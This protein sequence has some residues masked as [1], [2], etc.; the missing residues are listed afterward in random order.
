MSVTKRVGPV[1]GVAALALSGAAFAESGTTDQDLQAR[2]AD[3]EAQVAQLKSKDG[4]QWLTEQRAKEIR[5]IVQDVLQDADTR[6]S[7]LQGGMAAGHDSNGFFIGSDDGNFRL[8]VG[9]QVQ[10]RYMISIQDDDNNSTAPGVPPVVDTTRGGFEV[11]RAKL[12]FTGHV[13][14]PNWTYR[15]S[16]DFGQGGVFALDDGYINYDFDN[17][18]SFTVGQFKLPGLREEMVDSAYQQFV[19]RSLLASSFTLWRSQGVMLNYAGEWFRGSAAFSDGAL[20]ANSPSLGY[21]TEYAFSLR[22]EILFAGTWD[23]FNDFSSWKGEDFGFLLGGAF[24]IQ[25]GEY[26]TSI[27]A[28]G[29]ETQIIGLTVDGSLEFGGANLFGSFTWTD[30]DNDAGLDANPMGAV[31]QGGF[32]LTED[33]ELFARFEWGDADDIFGPSEDL[34]LLSLGATKFW[35]RHNLKWTTDVG[36]A[37]DEV[38]P[39]W[40]ANPR[41]ALTGWRSDVRGS[42]ADTQIVVRTQLQLLF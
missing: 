37:F 5:G 14:N 11:T 32:F 17:G 20:G 10:T 33:W 1:A 16:G 29:F 3:L 22:G 41:T 13:L 18:W 25:D 19:E 35:D 40:T 42:G 15:V 9:G 39:V 21:D 6:A 7:L 36:V 34:L 30:V 8:N 28:N 38:D 4:D 27:A 12:I 26:G 23:Q 24:H 31:V 2:I